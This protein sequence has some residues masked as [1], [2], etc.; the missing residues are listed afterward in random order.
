[1]TAREEGRALVAQVEGHLLLAAA[2]AEGRAAGVRV[3]DRLGWLTD[4]Q[5]EDLQRQLESEYLALARL[6]WR[7]TAERAEELRLEYEQRY[8]T[9]RTR[10]LAGFLPICALL[11]A[12]TLVVLT[13]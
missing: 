6:S 13:P 10:L 2:R 1:M 8:R 3:A 7:R 9:V 5:R 12:V 11:T 4:G